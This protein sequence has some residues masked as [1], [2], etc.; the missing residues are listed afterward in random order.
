MSGKQGLQELSSDFQL[1]VV[2]KYLSLQHDDFY[3]EAL[4]N[5]YPVTSRVEF[6]FPHSCKM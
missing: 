2:Q 4:Q 3:Y 6:I 1:T 5:F